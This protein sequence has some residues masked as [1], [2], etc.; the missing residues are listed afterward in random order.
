MHLCIT[1]LLKEA[2]ETSGN[3]SHRAFLAVPGSRAA[4]FLHSRRRHDQQPMRGETRDRDSGSPDRFQDGVWAN[5]ILFLIKKQKHIKTPPDKPTPR[6]P[7]TEAQTSWNMSIILNPYS[8]LNL[9]SG[10]FRSQSADSNPWDNS[11]PTCWSKSDLLIPSSCSSSPIHWL[12][13][14]RG[15]ICG[16]KLAAC[17]LVLSMWGVVMLVSVSLGHSWDSWVLLK[18]PH[19]VRCLWTRGSSPFSMHQS[20]LCSG[21]GLKQ[22]SSLSL[23]PLE[24]ALSFKWGTGLARCGSSGGVI[25]LCFLRL[26]WAFSSPRIQQFWLKT[27]HW[28]TK[29]FTKSKSYVDV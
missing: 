6:C 19:R 4:C 16:P 5:F 10:N 3:S 25:G 28:P 11:S 21:L 2:I 14:M 9:D 8:F 18:S 12:S 27:Y 17:G 26:C 22:P 20:N 24:A 23:A 29:T 7:V 15:L 1:H 13:T